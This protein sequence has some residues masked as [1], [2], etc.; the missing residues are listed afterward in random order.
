MYSWLFWPTVHL[1]EKEV[2]EDGHQ[3]DVFGVEDVSDHAGASGAKRLQ[4]LA[5][6]D[7]RHAKDVGQDA[8]RNANPK[9]GPRN[10]LWS[11]TERKLQLNPAIAYF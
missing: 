6:K 1:P 5:S 10:A 4:F 2:G 8:D 7:R 3:G 9:R 11:G